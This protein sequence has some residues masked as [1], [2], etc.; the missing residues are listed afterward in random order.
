MI[1][2]QDFTTE[3]N[4]S[5]ERFLDDFFNRIVPLA[6]EECQ[7][8]VLSGAM[9]S[10]KSLAV[11]FAINLLCTQYPDY[12]GAVGRI[13]KDIVKDTFFR[14]LKI[15]TP[16]EVL[17][18]DT[19]EFLEW[20][21]GSN[22]KIVG[23]GDGDTMKLR[24]NNLHCF[25]MEEV[26]EDAAM[27][28]KVELNYRALLEVFGRVRLNNAPNLIIL[29]TNPDDPSHWLH[30]KYIEK[31]GWVDG[32]KRE[33]KNRDPNVSVHYSKT[34]DNKFLKKGYEANLRKQL[35]EKQFQR[36]GLGR[37][38]SL[39]SEGIYYEYD[40]NVH[41]LD[42]KTYKID[43]R[44]P[45]NL[46]WDFNTAKGKPMSVCMSQYIRDVFHF[47]DELLIE[48][49]STRG[50][51]EAL[52]EDGF[53]EQF[54]PGGTNLIINGD[55]AGWQKHSSGN[56][57]DYGVMKQFFDH[58]PYKINYEIC[59]NRSNPPVK[60]RHN[61]CNLY[62]KDYTGRIRCWL[63]AKCENLNKGLKGGQLK[64]GN[65][66]KE[67]ETYTQHVCTAFGYNIFKNTRD[68][69]GVEDLDDLFD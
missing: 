68:S 12:Q 58:L 6:M 7:I 21:N 33:G 66:Y 26:T 11:Q 5:Q 18:V 59:V 38:V 15:M 50:I 31:A 45:I 35:S 65:T 4:E 37:W 39:E 27:A 8:I 69:G 22:F 49:S 67:L 24:S 44:F 51:L 10:G 30:E 28:G 60:S 64:K 2:L 42:D 56:M 1:K 43:Y 13:S 32:E 62:L 14:E 52:F 48:D 36:Y 57:S 63:Y 3:K 20:K 47:Y 46:N 16:E 40:E 9:G 23:W 55:A 61:V 41:Y 29:V 34:I 54:K 19:K 17:S 25:V 53:F